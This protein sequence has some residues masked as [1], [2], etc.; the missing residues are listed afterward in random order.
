MNAIW[1]VIFAIVLYILAY[2]FYASFLSKKIWKLDPNVV[3]PAIK[4]EDGFEYV[5]TQKY[6]VFG[7]HYSSIAGAAP[8]VGAS[9]AAIWGWLP[10]LL[11]LVLGTIFIGCVHDMGALVTSLRHDGRG[12]ADYLKELLGPEAVVLMYIVVFFLLVLVTA[13]FVHLIASLAAAFPGAVLSVWVEIPL[14]VF[15]GL[16]IRKKWKINLYVVTAIALAI[17]YGMI[18]VGYLVPIRFNY[19]TWIAIL[20]AYIFIAARLP[21]WLLVQPRDF[22]NAYQLVIMLGVVT[23]GIIAFVLTGPGQVVAPAVN[24]TPKGA[25]PIWPFVMITIACGATSGWHSIVGSGTTPKQV[26]SEPDAKL[27]AYGGMIGE[28]YLCLIALLCAVVGLGAAGYAK[29]YSAWGAASWT[30]I[31]A[32]GGA[33]FLEPLG[34]PVAIGVIF[35]AVVIKSFAMT[36]LDS[37]MRF[38]RIAFAESSRTW[39]LPKFF[40]ERTVSMIPGFAVIAILVYSGYQMTLW[41]LFGATNQILAGL[42]LLASAVFLKMLGRPNIYYIIP[43]I[44]MIITSM[45]AQA[46]MIINSYLPKQQWVLAFIGTVVFICGVG[47]MII[48]YKKWRTGMMAEAVPAAV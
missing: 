10:A 47:I 42:A 44:I 27:I 29:N 8:I 22:I 48:A 25:P 43:F 16:M 36:T 4:H 45:T 26:R 13:V 5:P 19:W 32:E 15:I 40:A 6:V 17:M 24:A 39:G 9:I 30:T 18:Y 46:W 37:A 1:I 2:R 11:W 3:T 28:G 31:F 34:L 35:M 41:P 23:V 14:A 20:L 33:T 7:H 12:I 38:T 21:V